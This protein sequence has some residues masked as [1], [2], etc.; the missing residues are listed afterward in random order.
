MKIIDV[1]AYDDEA[2]I[3]V[4]V[5]PDTAPS[6]DGTIPPEV[7]AAARQA[8]GRDD[9]VLDE[10]V[11]ESTGGEQSISYVLRPAGSQPWS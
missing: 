5:D 4:W 9:L 6:P 10:I 8:S 11:D 2:G 7:R 1:S 3:T